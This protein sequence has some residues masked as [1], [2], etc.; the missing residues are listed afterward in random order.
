MLETEKTVVYGSI[1]EKIVCND[2]SSIGCIVNHSINPYDN[3]KDITITFPTDGYKA[4]IEVKTQVPY[5]IRNAVTFPFRQWKKCTS[6]KF[7]LYV[8]VETNMP[9]K[10]VNKIYNIDT[11]GFNDKTLNYT[12]EWVDGEERVIIPINQDGVKYIRDLTTS[13]ILELKKFKTSLY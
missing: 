7:L 6:V 5:V 11:N 2:Y 12:I 9:C 8:V 1:G 10:Y 4:K 13:E 3:E